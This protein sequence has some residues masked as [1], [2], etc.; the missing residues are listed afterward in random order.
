MT[1]GSTVTVE[2]L[3]FGYAQ[4]PIL[5][6][7]SA[8]FGR[9]SM[10]A[11]VG[12]S[13]SGKS[14]LLYIIGLMLTP[15]S[16]SMRIDDE[17]VTDASDTARS[18]LRAQ[19]M[20]FVFQD[21]LLDPARSVIDNVMEPALYREPADG[22]RDEALQLLE[23]FEVTVD[24]DRKPG[25]ISGGQAQRVALCRAFLGEPGIILADEPTGNLDDETATVVWD[26][27]RAHADA[28]AAVVIAT[29]DAERALLCDAVLR[30]GH[31]S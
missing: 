28:G 30:I 21:A 29:H 19:K 10:T 22:L 3:S 20:G 5:E 9:G 18:R 4:Q 31:G 12:K 6:G 17:D 13:G 16:G 8:E 26:A 25:Q 11:L 27:L 24:P 15:W 7:F 1:R 2:D 14:T 23:Q